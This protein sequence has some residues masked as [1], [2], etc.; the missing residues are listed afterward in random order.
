MRIG[1]VALL[2]VVS[3]FAIGCGNEDLVE[4]TPAVNAAGDAQGT[5]ADLDLQKAKEL[6]EAGL[7]F[8]AQ[9]Q[10]EE[11][12]R[13]YDEA[14][15]LSSDTPGAYAG[16]GLAYSNLGQFQRAVQDLD[17]AIR[18]NPQNA[19][20]Y[21]T[22]G[23]AYGELG[24]FQLAARDFGQAL[25]L[26]PELIDIK[27]LLAQMQIKILE[28]QGTKVPAEEPNLPPVI[29]V[30]IANP[31]AAEPDTVV[32]LT[33]EAGDPDGDALTYRWLLDGK[34][35]GTG[36]SL[37]WNAPQPEG[38]YVVTVEVSDGKET[39]TRTVGLTV[40]NVPPKILGVT[41]KPM[42]GQGK[43]PSDHLLQRVA[44]FGGETVPPWTLSLEVEAV[45]P[46]E[47]P[48]GWGGR[49]GRGGGGRRAGHAVGAQTWTPQRVSKGT[50]IL[51]L[52]TVG[53]VREGTQP[54]SMEIK[55]PI[56]LSGTKL[57][58]SKSVGAP[59]LAVDFTAVP[60]PEGTAV[61]EYRWD[62][63]GDGVDDLVTPG[64]SATFTYK[65]EGAFVPVVTTWDANNSILGVGE[66]K[67]I[68]VRAGLAL[69][70]SKNKVLAGEQ[71]KISVTGLTPGGPLTLVI[72]D[73]SGKCQS[74]SFTADKKGRV[75]QRGDG[76]ELPGIHSEEVADKG[77][78]QDVLGSLAVSCAEGQVEAGGQCTQAAK[79][80][81]LAHLLSKT[82]GADQIILL[83][84][85]AGGYTADADAGCATDHLHA[86]FPST[87]KRQ[88]PN[89][90]Q[91]TVVIDGVAPPDGTVIT[92]WIDGNQVPLMVGEV[93]GG[94]YSIKVLQP[95][96]TFFDGKEIWFK[97]G[98]FF[99]NQTIRYSVGE[100][101]VLN[102]TAISSVGV[103]GVGGFTMDGR[104]PL[105][106]GIMP[107]GV[108]MVWFRYADP[109]SAG[110]G[111]GKVVR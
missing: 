104:G 81:L 69:G 108:N 72:C 4:V 26:K 6:Y 45:D 66:E 20:A 106:P 8:F 33:A 83:S 38:A 42:A 110:C 71:A 54:V 65:E 24:D 68:T 48:A 7:A 76:C 62:F 59:P 10:M 34:L 30:L 28:A 58:A 87:F 86:G 88:P 90:I 94:I 16:R 43:A 95:T 32:N 61:K 17:A 40:V 46:N 100:V 37:V 91:G 19:A 74:S 52:I 51:L 23:L 14:I 47:D 103:T 70:V 25:R 41:S 39:V 13:K 57:S 60:F 22:R 49:A 67:K 5:K 84:R 77:T 105:P 35:L 55:V 21:N 102:L 92:P 82:F 75:A 3:A 79:T 56:L 9:G 18:I 15:R 98:D 109:D 80:V 96:G 36:R 44:E 1:I 53:E 107:G 85:I 78:G 27:E 73:P 2:L 99:A 97:I 63:D 89:L 12:I 50:T 93:N 64:P 111:Y 11:A 31:L 29:G 101:Y